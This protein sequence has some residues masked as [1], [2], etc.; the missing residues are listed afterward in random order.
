MKRFTIRL[1]CLLFWLAA[2]GQQ[3]IVPFAMPLADSH[4]S[5]IVMESRPDTATKSSLRSSKISDTLSQSRIGGSEQTQAFATNTLLT[6]NWEAAIA[7]W[8]VYGYATNSWIVNDCAGSST[9]GTKAGYISRGGA[10]NNCVPTGNKQYAYTNTNILSVPNNQWSILYKQIDARCYTNMQI[11]LDYK[12]IG[13]TGYDEFDLVYSF[14][15]TTW[16]PYTAKASNVGAAW[17]PSGTINLPAAVNRSIFY[18]GF[19][20]TYDY[21]VNNQPPAAVD[22]INLTGLND[23]DLVITYTCSNCLS[24][25]GNLYNFSSASS[26]FAAGVVITGYS[27][28]FGASSTPSTSTSANPTGVTYSAAG[29][30]TVCLTV[31]DNFGCVQSICTVVPMST[32]PIE[33]LSF[34]GLPKACKDNELKWSTATETNNDRFE[35]ERCTDGINYVKI[36]E[37]P[38][39]GTSTQVLNYAYHDANSVTGVAYYRLKQV[40][41]NGTYSYSGIIAITND[42]VPKHVAYVT[43]M[44]GQL[45][46]ENYTGP[47]VIHY[48]DGSVTKI[49]GEISD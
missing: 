42:C 33:L 35:I 28:T 23:M 26:N 38:G 39:A 43:D 40:D 5:A 12:L 34:T 6:E 7:G 1:A 22:N 32:L 4:E 24:N 10:A 25:P 16:F 11:S 30:P 18:L 41:Y 49:Y 36:G 48:E 45:I 15:G 8:F 37:V 19:R 27:W 31:T 17:I 47:R 2:Q 14:N 13:E 20:F 9:P 44:L 46:Q 21:S 3:T 29:S